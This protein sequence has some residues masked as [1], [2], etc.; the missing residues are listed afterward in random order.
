[1]RWKEKAEASGMTMRKKRLR[2]WQ[3]LP[4]PSIPSPLGQNPSNICRSSRKIEWSDD[5][6]RVMVLLVNLL[7]S[8]SFYPF[9]KWVFGKK[10][11]FDNLLLWR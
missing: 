4:L 10:T 1:M 8:S 5:G 9:L 11:K 7:M 3:K 6:R 2:R